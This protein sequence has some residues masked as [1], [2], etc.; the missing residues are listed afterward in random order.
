MRVLVQ[1]LRGRER[2]KGEEG[3]ERKEKREKR[4]E[5]RDRR[6]DL[7]C[8]VDVISGFNGHFNTV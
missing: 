1:P 8:H 4:E 2:E 3:R 6:V 7:T 5:I